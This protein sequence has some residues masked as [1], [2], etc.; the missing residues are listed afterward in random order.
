MPHV[1]IPQDLF[2]QIQQVLPPSESA[3]AFVHQAV[4][5]KIAWKERR[6]EFLRLTDITRQALEERG[7]TE[8]DILEDFEK[9]RRGIAG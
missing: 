2:Q 1:D 5:E 4:R 6:E 7:L 3:D 8:E 9:H